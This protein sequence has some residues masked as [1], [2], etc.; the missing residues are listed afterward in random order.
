MGGASALIAA[1][2]VVAALGAAPAGAAVH[3]AGTRHAVPVKGTPNAGSGQLTYHGG[4]VM[5]KAS[6]T[7]AIFWEP[8]S[9]QNGNP[10]HV[11]ATYNSLIKRYFQDVGGQGLYQ[12]NTQYYQIKAGQTQHILNASSLAGTFVD[13]SAY[14]ASGCVDA[15]T[16]GN[17]LT[18]SQIQ[19]EV[20]HALTAKGWTPGPSKMFFVFTSFGEGSC[21]DASSSQCAFFGPQGYCAYHGAFTSGGKNVIYANMPYTGTDL[22]ACGTSTSPN[23]DFDADS[24]IN[25]TSH[26][27]MEAV[28]D[29]LLT[30]WYDAAGFEIG[31]KCA[32]DF[33]SVSLDG[34]QANQEWNGHFYILQREWDNARRGCVTSG[35]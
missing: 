1:A 31:D 19:A 6:R 26:E 27:H 24:T 15:Q 16:P 8:R 5:Q 2:S 17:C 35:P 28:T 33:G 32:W 22:N 30:A 25:V 10:T 13:T 34:G 11:S 18:D 4:P 20:R 21:F 3:G 29:P 9:L 12:N 7:Y 14:P 23:N